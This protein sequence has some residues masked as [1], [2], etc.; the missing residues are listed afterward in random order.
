MCE[1]RTILS[2]ETTCDQKV[3]PNKS[4]P[5]SDEC[6]SNHEVTLHDEMSCSMDAFLC[7]VDAHFQF[8]CDCHISCVQALNLHGACHL[9]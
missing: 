1:L 2:T 4:V 8:L 5:N 6:G 9:H 7:V 3:C